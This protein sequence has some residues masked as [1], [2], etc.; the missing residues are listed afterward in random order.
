MEKERQAGKNH[1]SSMEIKNIEWTHFLPNLYVSL[2]LVQGMQQLH[3]AKTMHIF[4][5]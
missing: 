1:W 3:P 5:E 4:V 2:I